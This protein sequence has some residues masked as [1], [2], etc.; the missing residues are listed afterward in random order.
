MFPPDA[1]LRLILTNIKSLLSE[2]TICST[3]LKVIC[4]LTSLT[5]DNQH[6]TQ[7]LLL[8]FVTKEKPELWVSL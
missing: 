3:D 4:V 8:P 2:L 5:F 7:L 6:L 1:A